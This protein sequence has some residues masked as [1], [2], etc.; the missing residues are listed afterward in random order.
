MPV[1]DLRYTGAAYSN[2]VDFTDGTSTMLGRRER[3]HLV[4][5]DTGSTV[6]VALA[7]GVIDPDD[8]GVGGDRSY[9][10]VQPLAGV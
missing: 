10:L 3:P 6:P 2:K 9:T 5:A 4:F 1:L 8:Q 7:N